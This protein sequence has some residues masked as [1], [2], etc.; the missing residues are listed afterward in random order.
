[1]THIGRG[2]WERELNY[3]DRPF[4]QVNCSEACAEPCL[5][6][7]RLV[8][9]R[10][11]CKVSM[12]EQRRIYLRRDENGPNWR[13]RHRGITQAKPGTVVEFSDYWGEEERSI[14]PEDFRAESENDT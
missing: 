4:S 14:R 1:M 12:A 5:R 2:R 8:F 11:G 13:V 10:P 3:L 7:V 9:N 6:E